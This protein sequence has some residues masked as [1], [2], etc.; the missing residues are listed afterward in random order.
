M[1]KHERDLKRIA[2]Y[3]MRFL[4]LPTKTLLARLNFGDLIKEA[5]IAIR[6]VLDERERN[7]TTES[8]IEKGKE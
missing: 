3:K 1:T 4:R 8:D 7:Q 2:E 5:Q 6:Q